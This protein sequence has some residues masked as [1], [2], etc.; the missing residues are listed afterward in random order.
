MTIFAVESK[1]PFPVFQ[2]GAQAN[3]LCTAGNILLLSL[4]DISNQERL[5]FKKNPIKCGMIVDQPLILFLFDFGTGGQ[6][7]AAF[8]ATLYKHEDLQLYDITNKEQRLLIEI[9][10]VD[11][12]TQILKV[13]RAVTMPPSLTLN[14]LSAVQDQL[15]HFDKFAYEKKLLEIY[16]HRTY[17]LIKKTKMYN[18]G[19]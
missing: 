15:S 11:F 4:S 14:F 18:L 10:A 7:D 8:D 17:D 6:Y 9:H 1:Y 19:E 2:E 16:R 13:I 3:F 12:R 5:A